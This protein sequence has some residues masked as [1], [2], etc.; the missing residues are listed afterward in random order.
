MWIIHITLNVIYCFKYI[1]WTYTV[2]K[3][4]LPV[5]ISV[6]Y[7]VCTDC[8]I[9]SVIWRT[10]W[11][12]STL[13]LALTSITKWQRAANMYFTDKIVHFFLLFLRPQARLR[14]GHYEPIIF[15]PKGSF[16]WKGGESNLDLVCHSCFLQGHKTKTGITSGAM[17]SLFAAFSQLKMVSFH[18]YTPH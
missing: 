1:I 5:D 8:S 7:A 16:S 18:I 10:V 11:L 2:C 13:S 6:I 14:Q 4:I 3:T 12:F 15:L 17:L 9:F